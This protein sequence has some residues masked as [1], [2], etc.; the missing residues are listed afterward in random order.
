MS[1]KKS[2]QQRQGDRR[3]SVCATAVVGKLLLSHPNFDV[4]AQD[5][6]GQTVL[7]YAVCRHEFK[8]I[9]LLL[10]HERTHVNLVQTKW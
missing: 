7:M 3:E 6:V 4:N 5:N 9:E 2:E 1:E 10:S 8:A